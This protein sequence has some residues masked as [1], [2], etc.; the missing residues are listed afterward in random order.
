MTQHDERYVTIDE[1]KRELPFTAADFDNLSQ[2]EFDALLEG[3]ADTNGL[4]ERESQRV[5]DWADTQWFPEQVTETTRR[6]DYV[7]KKELPLSNVPIQ[8]VDEVLIDGDA[9]TEFVAVD[10][11]LVIQS[12][13][14]R[15]W[16]TKFQSIEVTY[17]H[18]YDFVP[19]AVTGA[20]I[21]LVRN[22][23]DQIQSDGLTSESVG[24]ASYQYRTPS[25]VRAEAMDEVPEPPS[26]L[27]GAQ[28]V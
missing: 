21:R 19:E 5:E 27:G 15:N 18:G 9:F 25:E 12:E 24:S 16:P 13:V 7:D 8:S 10:T 4:M 11:H 1:V 28:L 14:R 3:D 22:A 26:Y 20:V 6:P 2:S 23:L 17:T